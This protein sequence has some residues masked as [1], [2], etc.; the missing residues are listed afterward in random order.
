M[1]SCDSDSSKQAFTKKNMV[2]G[3]KCYFIDYRWEFVKI[4][5]NAYLLTEN[6]DLNLFPV[7]T[8]CSFDANCGFPWIVHLWWF[9][10]ENSLKIHMKRIDW[11]KNIVSSVSSQQLSVAWTAETWQPTPYMSRVREH[12]MFRQGI[13]VTFVSRT[14]PSEINIW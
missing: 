8:T 10:G 12:A 4:L 9:S 5:C 2:Y 3:E 11:A 6:H 13:I 7:V 14:K 1:T